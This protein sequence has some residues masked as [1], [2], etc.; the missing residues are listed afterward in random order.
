MRLLWGSGAAF[1]GSFL[2]FLLPYFLVL[3]F[4]VMIGLPAITLAMLSLLA[5]LH[6]HAKRRPVWLVASAG[7]MGLSVLIKLITGFLVIIFV[8]GILI[9]QYQEFKGDRRWRNVLM[10]PLIWLLVFVGLVVPLILVLSGTGNIGQLISTHL[11]AEQVIDFRTQVQSTLS[12]HVQ[13]IRPL[14]ILTVVGIIFTIRSRRWQS[15]YLVAWFIT[16]LG[17]LIFHRPVWWH[18][19]L[20]LTIPAAMLAGLALNEVLNTLIQAAF[21]NSHIKLN[22]LL[23]TAAL[24]AIMVLLFRFRPN[25]SIQLINLSPKTFGTEPE[26]RPHP[27]IVYR[28]MKSLA[29]QTNWVVTDMPIFAF[30]IGV[31]VPPELAVF[32]VKRVETGDLVADEI[33][34]IVRQY[35]PEQ[36]MFGRFHFP[37]LTDELLVDYDLDYIDDEMEL[38]IR[39][40]LLK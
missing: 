2:I 6:W 22:G 19:T 14:F 5:L 40:G 38:Y 25:E 7:L 31:P 16:T 32:S 17:L 23:L 13:S 28:R 1:A 27:A 29:P 15:L 24:F 35:K 10:P 33:L 21:P 34:A 36:I 20:L 8:L 26:I 9:T 12:F 30:R 4:S 11:R 37:E 18:Q 39:K 3:S